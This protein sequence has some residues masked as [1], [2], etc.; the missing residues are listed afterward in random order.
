[1]SN[2]QSE[3]RTETP[4]ASA[5]NELNPQDFVRISN[6][7]VVQLKKL[8]SEDEETY[9]L[10]GLVNQKH[11]SSSDVEKMEKKSEKLNAVR[12]PT[13]KLQF[14]LVTKK[15][16]YLGETPS[17]IFITQYTVAVITT[18]KQL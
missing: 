12:L 10:N 5:N 15:A 3:R 6:S 13:K 4:Q 9:V 1:M 18:P 16:L 7:E 17:S 11:L 2:E 14:E 8:E